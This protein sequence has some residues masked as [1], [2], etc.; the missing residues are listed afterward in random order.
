MGTP[1]IS[2]PYWSRTTAALRDF[3]TERKTWRELMVFAR[4]EKI[5]G[6]LLRQ[7]LAYLEDRRLAMAVENP[8][9]SWL[10]QQSRLRPSLGTLGEFSCVEITA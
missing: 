10:W 4:K 3:L 1:S 5:P 2:D 7:Q 6:D 8:D 9:G